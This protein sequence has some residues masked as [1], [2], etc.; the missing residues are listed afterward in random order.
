MT[1]KII[2]CP[3]NSIRIGLVLSFLCQMAHLNWKSVSYSYTQ[4]LEAQG[5]PPGQPQ[6][7]HRKASQNWDD[8]RRVFGP[9]PFFEPQKIL[10]SRENKP[11]V[12]QLVDGRDG[13]KTR[14]CIDF[15]PMLEEPQLP[16]CLL[17]VVW[18]FRAWDS[19]SMKV[20]LHH[21]VTQL[22]FLSF[23][24]VVFKLC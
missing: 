19:D 16:R 20:K 10:I 21:Q 11:E 17:S 5:I 1:G 2:R 23:R 24:P 4:Q 13:I 8:L 3:L 7:C 15:Q 14:N 18:Y 9:N 6:T 22:G 12:S